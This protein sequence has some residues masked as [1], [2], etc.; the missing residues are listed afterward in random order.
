MTAEE[1]EREKRGQAAHA[2]GRRADEAASDYRRE[3]AG[4]NGDERVT[5]LV[6]PRPAEWPEADFI[7]GNPPFIGAKYLRSELEDGYVAAL[8]CRLSESPRSQRILRCFSGGRRRKRWRRRRPGRGGSGSSRPTASARPSARRVIAEAMTGR[9]KLRL[10]FAIPDHPWSDGGGFGGRADRDDGGRKRQKGRR[11]GGA[12]AG[13][14]SGAGGCGRR[15]GGDAGRGDG[16]NKPASRLAP[17]ST[18]LARC[19][20]TGESAAA[21]CR[22]LARASSSRGLRHGR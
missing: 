22:C 14:G 12:V 4:R 9:R 18:T 11:R 17:T 21:G 7:V 13:S 20:P 6:H 8:W 1:A 2:L 16:A 19:A 3:R 15:A 10:A 5:R